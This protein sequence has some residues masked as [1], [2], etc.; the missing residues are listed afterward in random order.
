M[1]EA[2]ACMWYLFFTKT[3]NFSHIIYIA[4]ARGLFVQCIVYVDT[5]SQI[6]YHDIRVGDYRF[7]YCLHFTYL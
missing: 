4:E 5:F 7:E 6:V 3:L 2:K 1:A